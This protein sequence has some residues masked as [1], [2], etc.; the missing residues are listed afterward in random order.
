VKVELKG[1]DEVQRKLRDLQARGRALHGSHRIPVGELLGPDFMRRHTRFAS[2]DAMVAASGFKVESAEDFAA[3]P[4]AD[5]DAFIRGATRFAGWQTMLG[6][7]GQEWA[8]RRL[9]LK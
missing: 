5:W 3:I 8:A 6:A 2:F 1:F 7:A 9:G 4:D